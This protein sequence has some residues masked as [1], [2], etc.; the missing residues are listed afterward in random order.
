MTKDWVLDVLA[1]LRTFAH[2]NDL[3]SLA[4]QL[5]DT[6]MV[7]AADISGSQFAPSGMKPGHERKARN[8]TDRIAASDL[9]Q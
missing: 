3:P 6:I 4:E 7:A 9:P 5:D 8:L 2:Q 1:D